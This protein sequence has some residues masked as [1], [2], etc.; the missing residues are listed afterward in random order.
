MRRLIML[1]AVA[2]CIVPIAAGAAEVKRG[3]TKSGKPHLEATEKVT[4]E[5]TVLSVNKS[6]RT[7]TI[8][9]AEG[10]TVA[11]KCGPQVKNFDQIHAKDTV[12]ITYT[13]KL[14]IEV[15]GP[16]EP[17][18]TAEVSENTAKPGEK[19]KAGVTQKV[20]YRANVT[21]VDMTA[22]TVTLKGSEGEETTVTARDPKNVGKVKVGDLVVFTYTQAL[23][24]SIAKSAAK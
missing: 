4:A 21:A 14:T 16:G 5:A 19:P 1:C 3:T 6:K 13:E 17:G 15:Q 22:G 7:V 9:T 10:D 2:L 18:S 12:H 8:L 23:A 11:V 20:Q 24:A